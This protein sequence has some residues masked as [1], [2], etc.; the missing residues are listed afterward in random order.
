MDWVESKSI[1]GLS[2][3]FAEI[4]VRREAFERLESSS[5]V[6][7]FEEV[8]QVR[9]ELDMG[10]VEVSLD[11]GVFDGS[12][13]AF[14]LPVGPGM[15]GFSQSVFDSMK[16]ADAVEGVSTKACGWA[17]TVFRQVGE[18]DAVVGEHGMDTI[19]N[20]LDKG[21]EE[22]SGGSHVCPFD[23]LDHSELRS[24]V[25]SNE[26]VELAFGSSNLGQ[27][28]V[29]EADR[30]GVELLPLGLVAFHVRQTADAMTL[31]TAMK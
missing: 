11:G 10:V 30:I 1:W 19:R 23:E 12:V 20:G 18:L 13:H 4:F 29:E 24:P 22:R 28:D 25:D 5:E 15:V 8:C 21:S 31:Q 27:V 3:E 7:G 14:D 17:L 9:F 26:Q 16:V 6:V 2:P